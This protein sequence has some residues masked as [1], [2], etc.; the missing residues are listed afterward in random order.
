MFKCLA[1]ECGRKFLILGRLSVE[2]RPLVTNFATENIRIVL[3]SPA[4]PF[5]GSKEFE[6]LKGE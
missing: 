6:E 3:D 1:P 4:C 2:K 5:C